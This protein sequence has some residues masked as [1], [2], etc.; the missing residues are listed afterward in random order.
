MKV[1]ETALLEVKIIEPNVFGD[2]RGFFYESFSAERYQALAGIKEVFVQD[3]LS[4]SSRGVLRGLHYQMKQTQGKLVSA[5]RGA[6]LD[7]AVDVRFG[8]PQ[9]GQHVAVELSEENKR[10]LWVPAGFAH[11]FIVLS[12]TADFSYKCTDYYHP[13][14]EKSILW[15]DPDLQIQWPEDIVPQLSKK[16]K[17]GV[18]L[19][20]MPERDLPLYE[21][22][23]L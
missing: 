11:G 3:N 12:E 8:S 7:V 2:E 19:K 9:F 15:N 1:I 4:R 18:C 6:V 10:Q 23:E 14:S 20:D 22:E 16:D 17:I 5:T 13:D 21:K